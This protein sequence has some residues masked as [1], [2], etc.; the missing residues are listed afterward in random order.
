MIIGCVKEIK[1]NEFRVG[2]TPVSVKAY[3]DHGHHVYL[4]KSAGI[5][6]G[7]NDED[8]LESGAKILNT[9]K[10]VW[11]I[12]EMIVKV[13]EPLASEYPYFREGLIIYTFLHLAADYEL[14]K[15]LMDKKVTGIAYETIADDTGLPCLRPMSEIAG[16][17]SVLEANRFLFKY[18]GGQGILIS[19]IAGVPHTKVTIFGAGIVGSAALAN[20][21]GLGAEVTI[22][23]INETKLSLLQQK[24]P[25]ITTLKSNEEN[26]I[27]SLKDA[28]IVI[29][30]VL[31]PGAHAPKMIKREY[32][33]WMKKGCVIADVAID[34]GGSTEVSRPTTH[35]NPVY[36]IDGIIHYMVA[37]IPGAVPKTATLA[38]NFT[39]LKYG[40]MIADL[41]LEKA[42]ENHAI[43][44]GLNTYQGQV[45]HQGVKE[46]LNL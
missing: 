21:Y 31:L 25:F 3:V 14:T 34:Q 40:L 4:E 20:A 27:T 16:R 9:A 44:L 41:G 28:D 32:Y 46:A 39:T 5:G 29:S 12:A 42:L 33:S 6:S 26:I 19:P 30:G 22:L 24:Y 2:L 8:Y 35:D 7:F 15:A 17:I 37:N 43:V 13:K 36:E 23:D 10:E 18:N 38:L 11:D 45:I 1:N